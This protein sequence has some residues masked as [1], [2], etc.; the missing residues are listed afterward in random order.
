MAS[1][2]YARVST[3]DQNLDLQ[4]DALNAAGCST[5]FEDK[6]SGAKSDRPGLADALA[7]VRDGDLLMVWKLDRLGRSMSHLIKTVND[8][9]SRGVGFK[10]PGGPPKTPTCGHFKN[11]HLKP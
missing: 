2:G 8:L 5:V 3:H 11:T 7:Y 10:S 6:I 4:R 9:E 1:I